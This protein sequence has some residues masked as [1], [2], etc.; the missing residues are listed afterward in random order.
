MEARVSRL[1]YWKRD[2][3]AYSIQITR[4]WRRKK[5]RAI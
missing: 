1:N 5:G 4:A 3:V 2:A